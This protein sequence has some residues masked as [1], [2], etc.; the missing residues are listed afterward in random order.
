MCA[1]GKLSRDIITMRDRR[2]VK[3]EVLGYEKSPFS[4]HLDT[5]LIF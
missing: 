5:R 4:L 3:K 1:L 2:P